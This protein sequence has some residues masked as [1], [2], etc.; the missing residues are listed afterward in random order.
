MPAMRI[1]IL[2]SSFFSELQ[3][4]IGLNATSVLEIRIFP[5]AESQRFIRNALTRIARNIPIPIRILFFNVLGI[6]ET[7]V[8][9]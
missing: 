2:A 7:F 8:S 4:I 3:N 6:S 9:V 5:I 1:F